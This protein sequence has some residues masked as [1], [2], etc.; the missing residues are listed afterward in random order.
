MLL[1]VVPFHG[2][3]WSLLLSFEEDAEA[4]RQIVRRKRR[5]NL[6]REE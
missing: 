6:V 4:G 5:N 1:Y 3:G 2:L